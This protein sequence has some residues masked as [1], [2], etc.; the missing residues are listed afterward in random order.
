MAT[1]KSLKLTISNLE[2]QL[3]SNSKMYLTNLKRAQDRALT[4]TL[5]Y[6]RLCGSF[7]TL[8]DE[9]ESN[10]NE[11]LAAIQ[12]PVNMDYEDAFALE[13]EGRPPRVTMHT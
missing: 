3:E 5:Q 4:A 2:K 6:Q 8:Q 7:R 12:N 13:L 11:L 1:K 10:V 9:V